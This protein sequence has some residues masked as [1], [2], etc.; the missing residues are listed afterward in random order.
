M[1]SF[2]KFWNHYSHFERKHWNWRYRIQILFIFVVYCYIKT[3]SSSIKYYYF[4][5]SFN[6]SNGNP[7]F[8][9]HIWIHWF[10]TYCVHLRIL[11]DFTRESSSQGKIVFLSVINFPVKGN[12]I[13]SWELDICGFQSHGSTYNI[14]WKWDAK[15]DHWR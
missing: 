6:P 2:Q 12:N 8:W 14:F 4:L 15:R 1:L 5:L 3:I 7:K 10:V 11:Y 13:G 9:S